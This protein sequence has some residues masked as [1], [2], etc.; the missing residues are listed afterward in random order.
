[1]ILQEEVGNFDLNKK[2]CLERRVDFVV[3][4]GGDLFL[5]VVLDL[6]LQVEELVGNLV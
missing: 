2:R 3:R 5:L 6:L 1:M 4:G